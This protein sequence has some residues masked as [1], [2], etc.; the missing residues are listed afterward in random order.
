MLGDVHELLQE[1]SS[2]HWEELTKSDSPHDV[3]SITLNS[4]DVMFIG[5]ILQK[6]RAALIDEVQETIMDSRIK[7]CDPD[8]V[9]AWLVKMF[10][11]QSLR[12]IAAII[13]K[14]VTD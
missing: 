2:L 11:D 9:T 5:K 14:S 10:K 7:L 12:L 4:E 6:F 3:S 13:N 8:S 1:E